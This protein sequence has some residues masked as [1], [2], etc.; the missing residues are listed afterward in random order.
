[1]HTRPAS[2]T[3]FASE[4]RVHGAS[5]TAILCSGSQRTLGQ[6]S[7]RDT[8]WRARNPD[9]THDG[10]MLARGVSTKQCAAAEVRRARSSLGILHRFALAR[11]P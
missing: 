11:L 10:P 7:M 6:G 8:L 1:M 9:G 4:G 2:S 5:E 3:E